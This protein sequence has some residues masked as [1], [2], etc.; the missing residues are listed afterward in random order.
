MTGSAVHM[1]NYL[2]CFFS[3]EPWNVLC[4]HWF[5]HLLD[6]NFTRGRSIW[7]N[8][9]QASLASPCKTSGVQ[10][11]LT[12]SRSRSCNRWSSCSFRLRFLCVINW[13]LAVG[14]IQRYPGLI[15]CQDVPLTSSR[16]LQEERLSANFS[17]CDLRIGQLR[18]SRFFRQNDP[19]LH[20]Q[21]D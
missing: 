13:T 19:N 3:T 7:R 20:R 4:E 12:K 21:Y 14:E 15:Q 5:Q 1:E 2:A 18:S 10:S 11:F 6:K 8:E 17:L 9:V 16:N